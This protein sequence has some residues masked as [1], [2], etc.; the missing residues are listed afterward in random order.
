MI[1]EQ[2]CTIFHFSSKA[3]FFS[4]KEKSSALMWQNVC[5]CQA[6]ARESFAARS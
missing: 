1:S 6:D 5:F 2:Y 3:P 4:K